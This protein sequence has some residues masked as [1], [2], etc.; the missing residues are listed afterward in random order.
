M[1]DAKA[2]CNVEEQDDK[3]KRKAAPKGKAKK[4]QGTIQTLHEF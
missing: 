4:A 1:N 2:D 3:K